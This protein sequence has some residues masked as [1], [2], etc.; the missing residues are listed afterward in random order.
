MKRYKLNCL[1]W[2]P[3]HIKFVLF[4]TS[5]AKCGVIT[6]YADDVKN[7]IKYSWNGDIYWNGKVPKDFQ[8]N[9]FMLDA[10]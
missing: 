3:T 7:F 6:I 1:E 2:N 9:K 10:F 5:G 4:D 8:D